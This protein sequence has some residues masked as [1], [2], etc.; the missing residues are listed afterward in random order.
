MR[1]GYQCRLKGA[2]RLQDGERE[3]EV[4]EIRGREGAGQQ[5]DRE[6]VD[7]RDE[8]LVE[9]A[10]DL[11]PDAP[12]SSKASAPRALWLA[13]PVGSV[14]ARVGTPTVPAAPGLAPS[15][16]TPAGGAEAR[17]P[18]AATR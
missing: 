12:G 5:D 14:P 16:S 17:S 10:P 1:S 7:A 11:G 2:G 9:H 3:D 13:H 18:L 6:E 15:S 4:A 8:S